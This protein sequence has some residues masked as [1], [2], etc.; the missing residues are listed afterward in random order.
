MSRLC[1][2]S[3]LVLPCIALFFRSA[4]LSRYLRICRVNVDVSP[5][6]GYD[7]CPNYI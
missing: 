1:Y 6:D 5:Y 7:F 3:G 4:E 2:W